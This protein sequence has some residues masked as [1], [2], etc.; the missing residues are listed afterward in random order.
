MSLGLIAFIALLF[1]PLWIISLFP[2][3]P[4]RYHLTTD[5]IRNSDNPIRLRWNGFAAFDIEE[6]DTPIPHR[7]LVL[8]RHSRTLPHFI[9]LPDTPESDEIIAAISAH[10]PRS[11]V[12]Y[13]QRCKSPPSPWQWTISLPPSIL[14]ACLIG[15]FGTPHVRSFFRSNGDLA[16]VLVFF[17]ATTAGPALLFAL[18]F[19]WRSPSFHA[20]IFL[21]GHALLVAMLSMLTALITTARSW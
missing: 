17:L 15:Y 9:T 11:Q 7:Q 3:K 4:R 20:T 21:M 10:L 13:T 2:G 19:R 12:P 8:V 16:A 6:L 1:L 14:Y 18:Y 5:G